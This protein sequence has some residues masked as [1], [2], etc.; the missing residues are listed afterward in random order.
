MV[1]PNVCSKVESKL[2]IKPKICHSGCHV[3]DGGSH[4][5]RELRYSESF[6]IL[7][8]QYSR[9]EMLHIKSIKSIT[10]FFVMKFNFVHVVSALIACT[11][12]IGLKTHPVQILSHQNITRCGGR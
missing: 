6:R 12:R 4:V 10:A 5:N 11:S 3:G 8:K 1:F 9:G 2:Q 7:R